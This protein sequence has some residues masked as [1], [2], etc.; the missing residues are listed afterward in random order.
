MFD[1]A[2][3]LKMTVGMLSCIM[4]SHELAEWQAYYKILQKEEQQ[5]ELERRAQ[6]GL[7]SNRRR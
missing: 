6:A 7:A 3:E 2:R 4:S 5:R 1:L